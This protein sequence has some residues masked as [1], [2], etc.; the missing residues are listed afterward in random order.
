MSRK[1][2]ECGP[3]LVQAGAA[4]ALAIE[5]GMVET[6]RRLRPGAGSPWPRPRPKVGRG[7]G[8]GGSRLSSVECCH[9]E[10]AH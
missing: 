3:K 7:L 8:G 10:D 2:F 4:R 6:L 5:D 9:P 1:V